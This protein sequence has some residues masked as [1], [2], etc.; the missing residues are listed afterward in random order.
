MKRNIM[1][2][3]IRETLQDAGNLQRWASEGATQ[4]LFTPAK[5]HGRIHGGGKLPLISTSLFNPRARIDSL[6]AKITYEWFDANVLTGAQERYFDPLLRR[7]QFYAR[8]TDASQRIYIPENLE[9]LSPWLLNEIG[10]NEVVVMSV[11]SADMMPG[12]LWR[13]LPIS[14]K[15]LAWVVCS[16]IDE[17]GVQKLMPKFVQPHAGISASIATERWWLPF[18]GPAAFNPRVLGGIDIPRAMS[19]FLDFC[20]LH[21]NKTATLAGRLN[22]RIKGGTRSRFCDAAFL[23]LAFWNEPFLTNEANRI[24][25]T[26]ATEFGGVD[27]SSL[28]SPGKSV[29]TQSLQF[30]RAA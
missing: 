4:D 14:D 16:G 6:P 20:K 8:M 3:A 5:V 24:F 29:Q 12:M 30:R 23:S 10:F 22:A 28:L 7:K 17:N 21:E 19:G 27:L 11:K 26:G 18:A 13:Y 9:P 2:Y 15:K 1:L 25:S